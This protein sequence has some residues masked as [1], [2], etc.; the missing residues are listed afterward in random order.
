MWLAS[1]D[2]G[3]SESRAFRLFSGREVRLSVPYRVVSS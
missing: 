3:E 1:R 2:V